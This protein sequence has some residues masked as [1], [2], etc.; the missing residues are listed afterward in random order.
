M[1]GDPRGR[2]ED[3]VYK[4]QQNVDPL[5]GAR[6]EGQFLG[7]LLRSSH[8][9]TLIQRIGALAIGFF[10]LACG[11]LCIYGALFRPDSYGNPV[12]SMVADAVALL[13]GIAFTLFGLRI[14]L[15]AL[16]IRR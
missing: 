3:K 14:Y 7:F 16:R 9:L 13:L 8:R 12:V 11:V 2:W 4:R 15:N 1:K 6:N 5:D 10:P